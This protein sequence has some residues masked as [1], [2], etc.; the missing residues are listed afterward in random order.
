MEERKNRVIIS[1]SRQFG[2]GGHKIAE[3]L[4]EHFELPIYDHRM[5]D[6]IAKE[7]GVDPR[8]LA[9]SLISPVFWRAMSADFQALWRTAWRKCSSVT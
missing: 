1:V 4:A 7:K 2:S 8:V 3:A 6:S 9:V 5:L